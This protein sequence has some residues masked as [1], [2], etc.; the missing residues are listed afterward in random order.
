MR[1]DSPGRAVPRRG[2]L[3]LLLFIT[4]A[5]V[6]L[7]AC[8]SAGPPKTLYV[9]GDPSATAPLS[10]RQTDLPI[11]EVHR[12]LVPDYLD[13]T[14]ILSRRANQLVPRRGSRW[15][16]RLS[17]GVMRS[18]TSAL[19][20]RLPRMVVVAAQPFKAPQWHVFVDVETFEGRPDGRVTL[21]ASWSIRDG[22]GTVLLSQR[23][24]IAETVAGR[25]DS[26]L[27]AA[28]TRSIDALAADIAAAVQSLES[29]A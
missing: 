4:L 13:S 29:A 10:I 9:L 23:T 26:A 28:M 20:A 11:L 27:V 25:S 18:L 12:V 5:L 17:V 14:D 16:E 8:R 24:R 15:A 21:A 1:V 19:A 6:A 7:P 22:A 3:A 2:L